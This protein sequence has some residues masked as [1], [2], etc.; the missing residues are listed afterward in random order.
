MSSP[1]TPAYELGFRSVDREF[2][3]RPLPVEGSIPE[4]LSGALI[5]NGPGKFEVGDERVN[6]W[7]DGLAMVRRYAFDD[8]EVRYTNRFLRTEAYENASDGRSVGEFA[9]GGG[10]TR[11]L[12]RW[13]RALGPPEST[14]NAC[15][16][17]ARLGDEYV[18][19]TEA[20]RWV[21]FDP[22][23][24]ETR[25]EFGFGDDLETHLASAHLVV[26]EHR[27]ETI[28][29]GTE[30]G[31]PHRFHLYRV[32]HGE[33]QRERIGS[34]TA[35]GPGYVHSVAVTAS[36]VVLVEV[37]LHVSI[38]R[39]LSPWTEGLL[40]MLEYRPERGTR[41]VAVDRV[42]GAVAVDL[43]TEPFF[44][45]HHV[46]AFETDGTI[47]MDLVE[48]EDDAIVHAL[49]FDTLREDAF[50]AAPDGRFVRYR[51]DLDDGTIARRRLYDGGLELPTV[52]PAVRTRPY[53]YAYGQATDR[54]GANGLA[55][56]DTERET[57]TEWWERS[58]YVEE[59]RVVRRPD[60]SAED[61][62][63]VLAPALDTKRERSMLLVFDAATLE[64]RARAYLPHA[65]PFGFHGRFFRDALE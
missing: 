14:D 30:F 52:P 63:V 35:E 43:V 3:A 11:A 9:T 34:V 33:P 53:R 47:A 32:P 50:T 40:D 17:V 12:F 21:A 26:D 29:Y 60:A 1:S 42:T 25:G 36:Y 24:L 22:V 5:R 48:Y 59:P 4:W 27:A 6:H 23:T 2:T 10:G 37:P 16:H 61:D 56:I 31:R 55:K 20:P 38:R 44:T 54:R 8:G 57:A 19:L 39:A 51:V 62:G 41:I 58:V 28:G 13:L 49:S 45:F 18:A 7:F 46:N 64:E 65:V 15:V